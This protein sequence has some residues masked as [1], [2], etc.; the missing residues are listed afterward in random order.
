MKLAP[1]DRLLLSC[2]GRLSKRWLIQIGDR[3]KNEKNIGNNTDFM[4]AS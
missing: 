4:Y 3:E 1:V 2:I